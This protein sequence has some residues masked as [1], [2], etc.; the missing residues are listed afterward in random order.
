MAMREIALRE[1]G[2]AVDGPA[3]Y[4]V[5]T[6]GY[7][8]GDNGRLLGIIAG[9][10]GLVATSAFLANLTMSYWVDGSTTVAPANQNGNVESPYATITQAL[11]AATATGLAGPF[12]VNVVPNSYV[13]EGA[14][15]CAI[16]VGDLNIINTAGPDSADKVMINT[17]NFTGAM[18]RVQLV[19]VQ[20][21][22]LLDVTSV[23]GFIPVGCALADVLFGPLVEAKDTTLVAL[24]AQPTVNNAT[25][26]NCQFPLFAPAVTFNVACN[27]FIKN[28]QLPNVFAFT[29]A[30][31]SLLRLDEA[32][33]GAFQRVSATSNAP[34]QVL[35]EPWV[36][37]GTD[38]ALA[39]D[40]I[41]SFPAY[42]FGVQPLLNP[43]SIYFIEYQV[44]VVIYTDAD[45]RVV[46][47][48]NIRIQASIDVDGLGVA[49]TTFNTV[50]APDVALL[51]AGLAGATTANIIASANGWTVQAQRPAGVACHARYKVS[52]KFVENVT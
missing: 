38:L 12:V 10:V 30:A 3:R 7:A 23:F 15:L 1:Q 44:Q 2:I 29:F 52:W 26:D 5:G 46:G 9:A 4:T 45:H 39:A 8:P 17:L 40:P 6:R 51:P 14:I 49:T 34:I 47:G 35:G 48:V 20:T 31:G 43:A 41:Q 33:W 25:F 42:T 11:A 16:A 32:T 28:S 22:A 37:S 36:A 24:S 13:A 21:T 50:P 19:G 18:A 27:C